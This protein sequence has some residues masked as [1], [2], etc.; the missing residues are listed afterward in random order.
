MHSR[1]RMCIR[2]FSAKDH[3]PARG[4]TMSIF[5][6]AALE[7][8]IPREH[9]AQ[10]R[11]ISR[12]SSRAPG[13]CP[14]SRSSTSFRRDTTSPRRA[15]IAGRAAIGN[16]CPGFSAA[17][18]S[19][20]ATRRQSAIPVD[21]P[22]EDDRQSAPVACRHRLVSSPCSAGWTLPFACRGNLDRVSSLRPIATPALLPF[23]IGIVP[24]RFGLSRR[25]HVRAIGSD[26]EARAVA[27]RAPR[28]AS[29]SSGLA[30]VRRDRQDAIPLV[31]VASDVARM[32]YRRASESRS[33]AR[34]GR[35]LSADGGGC[36]ARCW[37]DASRRLGTSRIHGRSRRPFIVLW[38][39]SPAI[40]RWI[41]LPPPASIGRTLS[42][43]DTQ[44][45]RLIARR[46]WHF[47]ET[48]VTAEDHMLPPD[49]FQ[50]DPVPVLA[51]R[52]S[53]TNLGLYLLSVAAARD[54]G[55]L[56]M[57]ED[58]RAAGSDA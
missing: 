56:G 25:S 14:I 35:I 43:P 21:R 44:I 40:A 4:S 47:F 29:C 57:I 24:R 38:L 58:G 30:D 33:T 11:S 7:G 15:S 27:V 34:S 28:R 12:E 2:I 37:R 5:F 49:N 36:S 23:I 18:G 10:S 26:L 55:W 46:T 3:I 19:R 41:S 53:P 48:F 52:T 45:L 54:F 17:V 9:A 31:R 6:E 16:C 22:L 51:H 42:D 20:T 39:L 1:F 8:R 13:W 32:D 50:E